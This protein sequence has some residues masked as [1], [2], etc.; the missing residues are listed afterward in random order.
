MAPDLTCSKLSLYRAHST[1]S[2]R[3]SCAPLARVFRR[4]IWLPYF[5]GL[6]NVPFKLSGFCLL[7]G[8]RHNYFTPP[9]EVFP[10]DFAF[11]GCLPRQLRVLLLLSPLHRSA[12]RVHEHSVVIAV[13]EFCRP[14]CPPPLAVGVPTQ[15]VE[16]FLFN[17][18]PPT[19]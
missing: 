2:K 4:Q 12:P 17:P 18:S 14:R 3:H 9:L 8:W 15:Q 11:S 10:C 7:F 19:H 1:L 16:L 5:P 6:A 13:S